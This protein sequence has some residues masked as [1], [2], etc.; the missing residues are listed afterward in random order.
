MPLDLAAGARCL[1]EPLAERQPNV[2]TNNRL[3]NIEDARI[4]DEA[5]EKWMLQVRGANLVDIPFIS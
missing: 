5:V 2:G 1:I 3:G 4:L